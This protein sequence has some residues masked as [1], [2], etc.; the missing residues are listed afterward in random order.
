MGLSVHLI[1]IEQQQQ[2]GGFHHQ[3]SLTN[4]QSF[5]SRTSEPV[6]V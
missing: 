6:F 3:F 5:Q 2:E 1:C 4:N